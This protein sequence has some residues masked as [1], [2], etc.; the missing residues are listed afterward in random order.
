MP[1]RQDD[2]VAWRSREAAGP[3]PVRRWLAMVAGLVLVV[4][5][6]AGA[7]LT[8]DARY[9]R[10]AV[11]AAAWAYLAAVL[12]AGRHR[13][14][15]TLV[16]GEH[17]PR[18]TEQRGLDER[19]DIGDLRAGLAA[20]ADVRADLGEL[21]ALRA[22]VAALR[23]DV[24]AD[25]GRLRGELAE[26]LDGEML[27]ER[28]V[29]R[30]RNTRPAAEEEPAFGVDGPAATGRPEAAAM[31]AAGPSTAAFSLAAQLPPPAADPARPRSTGGPAPDARLL[32]APEPLLG[33]ALWEDAG[34]PEPGLEWSRPV[35]HRRRTD[36]TDRPPLSDPADAV[37]SERRASAAGPPAA[38]RPAP[39]PVAAPS[40]DPAWAQ[41][42]LTGPW[43]DPLQGEPAGH[44]RLAEILAANAVAPADAPR[45]RHRYRQDDEPDD[46]LARVLGPRP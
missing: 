23:A 11:L 4:A 36:E 41:D 6:T 20:L 40:H 24:S 17:R 28:L 37:T 42:P 3:G 15:Q 25:L 9:L 29:M 14:E 32:P 27:V 8:D 45:R 22:E 34:T 38:F 21:A 39:G 1:S 19:A 44:A 31:P 10:L 16:T 30:T 13:G 7:F 18:R 35:P 5:A 46:V 26:Q 33:R 43:R 12:L 2:G